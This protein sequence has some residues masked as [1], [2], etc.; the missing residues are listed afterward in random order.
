[1]L[2]TILSLTSI[3]NIDS[4]ILNDMYRYVRNTLFLNIMLKSNKLY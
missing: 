2:S 1:M 3:L 4:Y